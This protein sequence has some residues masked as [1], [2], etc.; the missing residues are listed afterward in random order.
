MDM[1]QYQEAAR[2]TAIY[3]AEQGLLYTVLGLTGEAG[4]VAEKV[5]KMLRDG[6]ELDDKYRGKIARELGD[7]LWYVANVAH[8]IGVSLETVA[9]ANVNKLNDRKVRGKISGNGDE[10]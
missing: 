4:E 2:D 10:R 5:K 6:I 1:N 8:E 7:V 3:P 9:R